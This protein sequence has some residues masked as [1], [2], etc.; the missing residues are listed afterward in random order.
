VPGN[1]SSQ[2]GGAGMPPEQVTMAET[3]K[4]AGYVSILAFLSLSEDT[5]T[6]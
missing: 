4:A 6:D 3:F 1:V 2:K 5:T